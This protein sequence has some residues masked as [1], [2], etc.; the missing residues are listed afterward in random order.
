[1]FAVGDA[2]IG[3]GF[4]DDGSYRRQVR[5]RNMGKQVMRDMQVKTATY[6][7]E[8]ARA[9]RQIGSDPEYVRGEGIGHHAVGVGLGIFCAVGEMRDLKNH[10]DQKACG[11]MSQDESR[12]H[13][14]RA[15]IE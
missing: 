5:V 7:L 14:P 2:E 13:S 12:D 8:D 9:R 15:G 6:P 4:L 1:V 10:P 3:S 11:N